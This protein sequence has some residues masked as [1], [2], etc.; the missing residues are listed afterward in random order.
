MIIMY[1]IWQLFQGFTRFIFQPKIVPI[2]S[3]VITDVNDIFFFTRNYIYI[4]KYISG[5]PLPP[6]RYGMMP[7]DSKAG[8]A[9]FGS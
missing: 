6:L 2:Y 5:T 4:Y 3:M 8:A 9:A 7:Q 1:D